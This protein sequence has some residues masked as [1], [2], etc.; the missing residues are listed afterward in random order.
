MHDKLE[1][2]PLEY[3]KYDR[4]TSLASLACQILQL[5]FD[6]GYEWSFEG[7]CLRRF[8]YHRISAGALRRGGPFKPGGVTTVFY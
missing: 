4:A 6:Q 3:R 8:I 7:V 2:P 1:K 5:L